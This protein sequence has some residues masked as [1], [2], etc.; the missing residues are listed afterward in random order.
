[1]LFRSKTPPSAQRILAIFGIIAMMTLLPFLLNDEPSQEAMAYR[2]KISIISADQALNRIMYPQGAGTLLFAYASWCPYCKRQLP[3]IIEIHDEYTARGIEVFAVSME[4]DIDQL[5]DFLSSNY[6]NLP[7]TPYMFEAD[8]R[9]P[10]VRSLQLSGA[11]FQGGIPYMAI[12]DHN[13]KLV[14]EYQGFVDKEPL[15]RGL[16]QYLSTAH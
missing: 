13:G 7:L 11:S 3:S 6:P 12:F 2:S 8:Q 9:G 4:A 5:S 15:I 10:F 1:M 14:E 16:E